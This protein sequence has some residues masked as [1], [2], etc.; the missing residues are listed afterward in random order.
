M[1]TPRSEELTQPH[2]LEVPVSTHHPQRRPLFAAAAALSLAAG[3]A[4]APQLAQP[5]A[6]QSPTTAWQNGAFS[7]DTGGVVGR[8][9][10]V[11]GQPNTAAAQSLPLGNGSL[12]VAAWAANGFTA[13]LNR[14][15]TM[16][17]RLSPGQVQIP[18]L[19]A[20]T[21]ASDFSGHLDL[22]NGV[23]DESGGG[24]TLRA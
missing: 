22:Y 4:L 6:A 3:L 8:S 10:V 21:T 7:V 9:D 1:R 11:L 17:Y 2:L 18:G 23:L 12:G 13:Q 14:S 5:A 16:P 20:M 24:M 19:G 15:D